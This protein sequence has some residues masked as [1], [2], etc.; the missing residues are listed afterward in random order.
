MNMGT[1]GVDDYD[2]DL[3]LSSPETRNPFSNAPKL[4]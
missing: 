1:E 4:K 3:N 2:F